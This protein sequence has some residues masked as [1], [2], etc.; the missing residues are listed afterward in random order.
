MQRTN[1]WHEQRKG[2]FTASKADNLLGKLTLKTTTQKIENYAMQKACEDFFGLSEEEEF[3]SFDMQR[4]IDLEPLAF[5]KLKSELALQ[6]IEVEQVGFIS[7]DEYSGASPDG[8][9]SNG[10]NIEI[11]CP[12]IETFNKLVLTDEIDSK[13]FAQMQMQMLATNAQKTHFFNYVI[14]NGVEYSYRIEV[15]R[16]E[17]TISLLQE[18]IKYAAEIKNEFLKTLNNK[19]KK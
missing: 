5:D 14:H 8:K 2:K 1:E 16:C 13:Y 19:L 18:R 17:E 11:K 7:I 9:C 12:K 6:F 4:G 15:L 10:D 3:I